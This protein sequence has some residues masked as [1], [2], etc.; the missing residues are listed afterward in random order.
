LRKTEII[1][2]LRAAG[3]KKTPVRISVIE[4]LM[5]DESALSQPQLAHRLGKHESRITLYR[6]LRDLEEVRLIYRVYD[7]DGVVK[8]A[9]QKSH[10][11]HN[12]LHFNC[13]TCHDV[14]CLE[15][16]NTIV[17][18]VPQG[19]KINAFRFTIEGV[20]QKCNQF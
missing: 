18:Q 9:L 1:E 10:H 14:V 3:L 8:Y 13:I 2:S 16:T 7:N 12:H 15:T 17:P 20:C 11:D 5:D 19:Y 6:V 4:T